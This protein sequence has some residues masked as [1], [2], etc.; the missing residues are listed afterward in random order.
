MLS[1]LN[2]LLLIV[3]R[4]FKSAFNSPHLKKFS[5]V[6]G[7][8]GRK[9]YWSTKKGGITLDVVVTMAKNGKKT[10]KNAT[11]VCRG[12]QLYLDYDTIFFF[13]GHQT[14]HKNTEG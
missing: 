5:F 8:K 1:S 3:Q 2:W 4:D 14:R 6:L 7:Q 12:I 10:N 11:E 9:V 13:C